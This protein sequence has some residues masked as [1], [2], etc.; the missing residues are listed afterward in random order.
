MAKMFLT[1]SVKMKLKFILNAI[2]LEIFF[3]GS[4]SFAHCL[5]MRNSAFN[6]FLLQNV[7]LHV[8]FGS[9]EYAKSQINA[10]CFT[11]SLTSAY[12]I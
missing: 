3:T 11:M 9:R 8:N 6:V 1:S 2:R 7:N 5:H 12:R 10:E 4:G